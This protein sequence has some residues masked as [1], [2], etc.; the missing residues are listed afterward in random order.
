MAGLVRRPKN[1]IAGGVFIAAGATFAAMSLQFHMGNLTHMG[2][3]YFPTALAVILAGLGVAIAA[4]AFVGEVVE[5]PSV[6]WRPLAMVMGGIVLF[7]LLL[8][9]AGLVPSIIVLVMV[10]LLGSRRTTFLF[11]SSLAVLLSAFCYAVFVRALQL[12]LD[13][14]G[15]WFGG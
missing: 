9:G 4:M 5:L 1:L 2:P 8:R 3:G 13:A 15:V 12:P 10:A 6:S 7:A 14:F 11:A